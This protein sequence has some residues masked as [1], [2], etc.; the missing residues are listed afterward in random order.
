MMS[1]ILF[2]VK[3]RL[4]IALDNEGQQ[5]VRKLQDRKFN[6]DTEMND[7]NE[8]DILDGVAYDHKKDKELETQKRNEN[9]RVVLT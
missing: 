9:R 6:P 5:M 2:Q 8:L 7:N 1:I 4:L 3:D